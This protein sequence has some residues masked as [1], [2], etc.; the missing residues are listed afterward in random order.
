MSGVSGTSA[1]AAMLEGSVPPPRPVIPWTF[2]FSPLL[3]LGDCV[4]F[5]ARRANRDML[6]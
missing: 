5:F 1:D 4:R 3:F 6:S 2:A